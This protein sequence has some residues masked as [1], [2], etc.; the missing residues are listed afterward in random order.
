MMPPRSPNSH[1]PY[2]T[3][4]SQIA[5]IIAPLFICAGL[6]FIWGRLDKPFDSMMV[7]NLAL[8]LGMPALIFSTLTKLQVPSEEFLRMGGIYGV[9][10]A[11]SL[12]MAIVITKALRI[13]LRTYVPVLAFSNTGNMGL[14]LTLFA[15]GQE[16]LTLGICIFVI[17]SICGLTLGAGIYSGRTSFDLIYRNPLIYAI[18]AALFFMV[19]S[20]KPP[21]W[22]A[23]TTEILGGMAIPMLI[24]SL[25]VAMSRLE[26][27]SFPRS[28]GLSA[29]KLAVGFLIG[30]G[31]A[32][33]FG[34]TGVERGVLILLCSMPVAVHNYLFAQRYDRSPSEIAGMVLISTGMSYATLP[35]LLWYVL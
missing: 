8:N 11:A 35:A 20:Q 23:N 28:A 27:R 9:S 32:E 16:G 4:L 15:F 3:V 31:V 21:Q 24:I 34:L 7:T 33:L 29:I 25:G 17:A 5:S 13:D 1:K 10:I 2:I 30:L 22:L 19:T 12:V 26:V 6:G 18:V 14:P